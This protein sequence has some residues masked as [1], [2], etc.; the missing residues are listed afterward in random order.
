MPFWKCSKQTNAKAYRPLTIISV[1]RRSIPHTPRTQIERLRTSCAKAWADIA[2]KIRPRYLVHMA[3][4]ERSGASRSS[5]T[6]SLISM[7]SCLAF[8]LL[9]FPPWRSTSTRIPATS[10]SVSS[11]HRGD[12]GMTRDPIARMVPMIHWK[13]RGKRQDQWDSM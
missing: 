12:S 2:N 9:G 10:W 4:Y 11:S 5:K 3:R 1:F 6:A 8:S 13:K 7:Y